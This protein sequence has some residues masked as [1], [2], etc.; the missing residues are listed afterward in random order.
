MNKLPVSVIRQ[1]HV[2]SVRPDIGERLQSFPALKKE[3]DSSV[4]SVDMTTLRFRGGDS[5]ETI[6]LKLAYETTI[7][8]V[9]ELLKKDAGSYELRTTFPN[10]TYRDETETLLTAGLVPS[11]TVFIEPTK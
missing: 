3:D 9:F 4:D 5:H 6:V 8:Q 10:R 1:G 11:A 2:I 7:G